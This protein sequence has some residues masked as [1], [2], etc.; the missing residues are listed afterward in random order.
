MPWPKDHIN[1]VKLVT[2]VTKWVI[3]DNLPFSMVDSEA[4]LLIMKQATKEKYNPVSS[5]IALSRTRIPQLYQFIS[6]HG[7]KIVDEEN[8]NLNGVTLQLTSSAT[9]VAFQ[10]LTFH[11]IT[12]QFKIKRLL[13]KLK[14]FPEQ[15]TGENITEKV[16]SLIKE[17]HLEKM[18]HTWATTDGCSNVVKTMRLSKGIKSNLWFAGHQTHLIVTQALQSV[19]EWVVIQEKL[20]KLV[21]H[22][23]HLVKS[24]SI[25]KKIAIEYK[26][27]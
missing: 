10:S 2:E 16:Y 9:N 5:R 25:L 3:T 7:K 22:F 21:G 12:V 24:T 1:N 11:F 19:P 17:M 6:D 27:N 23:N 26:E 15:H 20:N 18:T 14:S 8:L 4:F 13:V